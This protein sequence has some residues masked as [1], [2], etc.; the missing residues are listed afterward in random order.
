MFTVDIFEFPN[1][2]LLIIQMGVFHEHC[3]PMAMALATSSCTSMD[4]A[5]G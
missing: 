5:D 1:L 3:P 2:Y 4:P